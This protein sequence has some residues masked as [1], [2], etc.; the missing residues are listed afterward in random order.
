MKIDDVE[1]RELIPGT[2]VRFIHSDR[3]TVA[4]WHFDPDIDLPE[5]SHPHDQITNILEGEFELTVDGV[6]EVLSAGRRLLARPRRLSLIRS[7]SRSRSR[8]RRRIPAALHSPA[9]TKQTDLTTHRGGCHCGKVK[10]EVDAPAELEAQLCNCSICSMT[11]YLHLLHP[12]RHQVLLHPT[13][14]SGRGQRQCPL[15]RAGNHCQDSNYG[16]R[17]APLGRTRK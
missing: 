4:H 8:S 16:F 14:Q 5:H 15:P 1:E 12:L 3:M 2:R 6:P 11:A 17:W 13:L 9:M 10:F 7:R